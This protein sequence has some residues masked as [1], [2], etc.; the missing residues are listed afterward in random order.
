[1][2]SGGEAYLSLSL[3]G[4]KV[5]VREVA[6]DWLIQ[7]RQLGIDQKMVMSGIDT[8]G[9]G[10][11]HSHTTKPE[12]N[13]RLGRQRVAILDV[14]EINGGARRGGSGPTTRWHLAISDCG[15]RHP[16]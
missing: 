8:I 3:A 4:S 12:M 2:L 16:D 11:C 9:A 7:R 1:V 10:R 14:N 6:W 15:R 13:D 5:E